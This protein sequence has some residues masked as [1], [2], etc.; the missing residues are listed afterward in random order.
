[1]EHVL[2]SFEMSVVPDR[3]SCHCPVWQRAVTHVQRANSCSSSRCY[4]RH[5]LRYLLPHLCP[6]L[7]PQ[8]E[9]WQQCPCA[10]TSPAPQPHAFAWT[11]LHQW[12]KPGYEQWGWA[13]IPAAASAAVTSSKL[14]SWCPGWAAGHH[15]P[16]QQLACRS[17]N[18][19]TLWDIIG[20]I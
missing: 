7:P 13:Q 18:K 6:W 19:H 17:S 9:I 20:I 10:H 15:G 16:I 14:E 4:H 8:Q 5:P 12:L 3:H 1:M 2:I 11:H